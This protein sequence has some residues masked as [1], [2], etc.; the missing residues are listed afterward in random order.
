[1][2]RT[3]PVR[4]ILSKAQDADLRA[5]ALKAYPRECCGLLVGHGAAEVIVTGVIPAANLADDPAQRFL[6]DPQVQFDQLRA[7]RAG[8]ERIV[9]HYHSHPD[10]RAELSRH[11]RAMADDPEA[12]WVVMAVEDGRTVLPR[13]FRCPG[14]APPISVEIA[15]E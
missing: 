5:A 14:E 11:D 10:G 7:L 13:A 3:L 1:M 4:L 12:V 15:V 9:G 8:P 6:I 2:T